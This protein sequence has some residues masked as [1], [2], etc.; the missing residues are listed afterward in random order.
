[1]L[2]MPRPR[3]AQGRPG[4]PVIPAGWAEAHSHVIDRALSTASTVTI[5]PAGG[6]SQWNEG[7]GRT[8][9]QPAA[10]VYDGPAELMA[11][12][13]GPA[14]DRGRGP[15]QDPG[16]RRDP[17]LRRLGLVAVDHVIT[18]D[19]GDPDPMLAGR[20]LHVSAIE[21]GTR[22]FSRVLLAVLLD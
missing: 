10:A 3:Q 18:V 22:R 12:D 1:V 21:R 19:A 4:T 7:L 14:R 9:T 6:T 15:D 11:A 17:A 13:H 16:L 8:V 2:V 20:T 5:G